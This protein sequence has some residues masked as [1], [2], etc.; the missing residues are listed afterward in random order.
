MTSHE[1]KEYCVNN[2][3]R[4]YNL[5]RGYRSFVTKRNK[6]PLEPRVIQGKI[7]KSTAAKPTPVKNR[8]LD[9]PEGRNR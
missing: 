4:E 6:N 5:D 9:T 7:S 8:L 3:C 2:F 1:N